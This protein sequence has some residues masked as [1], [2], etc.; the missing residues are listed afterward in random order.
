MQPELQ[1][2]PIEFKA[3]WRSGMLALFG[4]LTIFVLAALTIPIDG[5]VAADGQIAVEFQKKPVQHQ[6]GGVI[7]KVLVQ[8]GEVVKKD[9]LVAVLTSADISAEHTMSELREFGLHAT[10]FRLLAEQNNLRN[11]DFPKTFTNRSQ[12]RSELQ[13]ILA[14]EQLNFDMR[15]RRFAAERDALQDSIQ[16]LKI[17]VEATNATITS[18]KRQASLLETDLIRRRSL[19]NS[20]FISEA[21]FSEFET[22]IAEVEAQVQKDLADKARAERNQIETQSRLAQL[23]N[24][25]K[26]SASEKLAEVNLEL[27]LSSE[28]LMA[29]GDKEERLNLRSPADGRVVGILV[30]APGAVL[31]PG[32]TLMNVVPENEKRLIVARVPS[33]QIDGIVPGLPVRVRISARMQEALLEGT[34]ETVSADKVDDERNGGAFYTVRVGVDS[35]QLKNSGLIS[36]EVGMP[37]QVLLTLD[38]RTFFSYLVRPMR[39][40]FDRALRE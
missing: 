39:K 4:I 13:R 21:G 2:P 28:K 30:Q 36:V 5:G 3:Q 24:E 16:R 10:R 25:R 26:S 34:I 6:N 8:E 32:Q 17:E 38:R 14:L 12:E 1:L 29:A 33:H 31:T 9:Q 11:L 37:V 35:S 7:Q 40:F 22:K 18:R 27:E 15:Y 20:G 19:M 23:A